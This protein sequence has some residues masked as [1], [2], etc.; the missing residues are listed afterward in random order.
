MKLI[1]IKIHS[2]DTTIWYKSKK[3]K[4]RMEALN[5]SIEHLKRVRDLYLKEREGK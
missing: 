5:V 1:V 4:S 3:F 2:D